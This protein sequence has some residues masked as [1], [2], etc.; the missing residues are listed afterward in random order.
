MNGSI[1]L[2]AKERRS[3]L[4]LHRL[5]RAPRRALVLLLLASGRS[6]RQIARDTLASPRSIAAVKRDF[7]RGGL[8]HVLETKPQSVS[9][10][11]W[12]IVV[13]RWL[14]SFTPRDFRFFRGRCSCELP[15]LLLWEREGI[16]LSPET[17]RRGM[18]RMDFV[19]RRPRPM[20]GWICRSFVACSGSRGRP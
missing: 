3:C 8:A 16:C 2:S 13:T 18:R 6:Y 17:V 12:L 9:V 11:S 10:T 20:V 7:E 5:A 15:A 19:W 1:R 14:L 4:T